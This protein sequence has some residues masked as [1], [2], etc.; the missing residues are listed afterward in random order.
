[1]ALLRNKGREKCVLQIGKLRLKKG[2]RVAKTA[3]RIHFVD[4]LFLWVPT[5]GN[6]P[7]TKR[8]E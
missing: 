4:D 2:Q 7:F 3:L 1:M 5:A 8:Q 6:F